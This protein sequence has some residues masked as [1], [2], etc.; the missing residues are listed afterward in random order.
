[1]IAKINPVQSQGS[2]TPLAAGS[3][4]KI[5]VGWY[6]VLA[7]GWSWTFWLVAVF[8]G[9]SVNSPIGKL[10]GLLGLLGP[11]LAGIG[12]TYAAQDRDVRR[13][14]W[15]RIFSLRRIGARGAA[16][17]LLFAPALMLLAVG[18]DLLTG[19]GLAPFQKTIQPFLSQPL[20]L[21]PMALGVFF[22]GP[23]PEELGWR[24]YALDRLQARWGAP[25]AS[26]ILGAVWAAWH[27]PLF[28]IKDTYQYGLGAGSLEFWLFMLGILPLS[29][30]FTWLYNRTQRSTLAVI[31]FHFV[32][33]FTDEFLNLSRATDIYSTI[34]WIAAAAAILILSARKT[35]PAQRT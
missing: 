18:L 12:L 28:F 3:T 35:R 29:V 8:L 1:M 25:L 30:I 31:L 33:V 7:L 4:Q 34:L 16:L 10:L 2:S 17:I 26:L 14:Y 27:L 19:G 6:F 21:I 32:I 15:Q 11:M 20:A 9:L 13:D 23:F 5:S 22:L 24:G